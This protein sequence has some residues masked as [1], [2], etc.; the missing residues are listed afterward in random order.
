MRV[1]KWLRMTMREIVRAP[2]VAADVDEE[3]RFHL[4][5]QTEHNVRAGLSPEQARRE[6]LLAFGGVLRHQEGMRDEQPARRL[7]RLV[8]DVRFALRMLRNSPGFAIAAVLTLALGIGGN[9]A[10]FSAVNG[11]LLHPLPYPE[12]D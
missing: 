5:M 11:V 6:A 9:T 2:A 3:M 1:Y 8:H 7:G 10:V 4:A 12:A